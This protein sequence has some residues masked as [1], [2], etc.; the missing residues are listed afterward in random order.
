MFYIGQTGRRFEERFKEHLP[1]KNVINSK[2]T[3]AQHLID[4]DH[5]YTNFSVNLKPIHFCKKGRYMNALE[6]YEIYKAAKSQKECLLNDMVSFKSNAL[7]DTVIQKLAQTWR[8]RPTY[9][10]FGL[11]TASACLLSRRCASSPLAQYECLNSV[12]FMFYVCVF[13]NLSLIHI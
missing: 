13:M 10:C 9:L 6:E 7:F 1:M 8:V 2:S 5:S 11:Y 3:Y 4:C 12:F